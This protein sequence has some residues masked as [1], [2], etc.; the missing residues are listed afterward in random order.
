MKFEQETYNV[1][2]ELFDTKYIKNLKYDSFLTT[3]K[4]NSFEVDDKNLA[5]NQQ[6]FKKVNNLLGFC[7]HQTLQINFNIYCFEEKEYFLFTNYSE[8]NSD[9]GLKKGPKFKIV[10]LFEDHPQ[11]NYSSYDE[12]KFIFNYLDHNFVFMTK[13]QIYVFDYDQFKIDKQESKLNVELYLGIFEFSFK[14][15]F[16]KII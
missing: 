9:K 2:F 16:N 1:E 4:D 12:L 5:K 13:S 7:K 3:H 14:F 6:N 10:D 11:L 15:S 8:M